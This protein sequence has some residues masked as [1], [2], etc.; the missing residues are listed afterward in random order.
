MGVWER[1]PAGLEI[2]L[3]N[4]ELRRRLPRDAARLRADDVIGSP[5][6]VRGYDVDPRFGGPRGARDGARSARRAGSGADPRLRAQPRRA[7]PPVGRSSIPSAS[8]GH[9]GRARASTGRVPGDGWRGRSPMARDPYFPA[10][11][12]RRPARTR[13]RR[14]ARRGD[15]RR[16]SRS[17]SSATALRCDMAMLMT[18]EVF[19][20]TWG[21]RAGPAAGRRLLADADRPRSATHPDLV[22]IA[23]AYWDLE[24]TLQQQGFDFC[25]DKRLYDRLVQRVGR[26]GA[27]A[28]A[29]RRRLPGT[30]RSASSRTTTSRAPRPRSR[31]RRHAR[32]RS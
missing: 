4:P 7:R 10:V 8:S 23:E 32:R 29:G 21:E 16:W 25:Y 24:W 28:P 13:S 6:C 22:F 30:A 14:P 19:A 12:R 1:S 31:R 15:R 11:A 26:V 17:A 18:N 3:R 20:R 2:A 9:R 5:Y 27:R